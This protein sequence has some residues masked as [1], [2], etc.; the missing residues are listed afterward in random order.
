MKSEPIDDRQ[1]G[2]VEHEWGSL[3]IPTRSARGVY[4]V[5]SLF[6]IARW[7]FDKHRIHPSYQMNWRRKFKLAYRMYR[8]TRKVRTGTSYKAHLA[9]AAKLLEI[10]PETAGVVV[11][12]GCWLGGSTVNLSLICD[13]VGR[14]L[15]VYDSFEGLPVA[16]PGDHH[17]KPES[18]SMFRGD[19]ERVQENVRRHGVI[20]RCQFRKGWFNETLPSHTEPVVLCFLDVDFQASL[21]DCIVNLWPRL[22]EQ[23]YVFVDEFMYL[24]YCALFF[25]ERFWKQYFDAPPPGLMGAGTGVGVGQHYLGPFD[26]S[27]DPTSVAYTRKDFYGL[28]DYVREE[29]ES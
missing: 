29:R 21:H 26:W 25:S 9:M 6:L 13:I 15:I 24:D 17:A 27:T 1:D 16:E 7:G 28:W 20:G 3:A 23:G 4:N 11:E 5:L 19:L 14:D 12:C 10:P 2:W 22:T 18:R 8:N